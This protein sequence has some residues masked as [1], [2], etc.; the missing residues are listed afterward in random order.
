LIAL[1]LFF[2]DEIG[3]VLLLIY[4]IV[5]GL[6]TFAPLVKLAPTLLSKYFLQVTF[7]IF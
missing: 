4:L 3:G 5:Y 1:L 7:F 2:G 6:G